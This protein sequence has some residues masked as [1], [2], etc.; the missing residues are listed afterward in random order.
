MACPSAHGMA[1]NIP[2]EFAPG[3]DFLFHLMYIYNGGSIRLDRP[4]PQLDR[5]VFAGVGNPQITA[6]RQVQH[7]LLVW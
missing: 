6:Q 2:S 4:M 7:R 5:L 3:M 1:L